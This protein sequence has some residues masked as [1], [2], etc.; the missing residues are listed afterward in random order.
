MK[1]S[2]SG[3]VI[4]PVNESIKYFWKNIISVALKLLY[5]LS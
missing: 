4:A 2:L 1:M 5:I 3:D